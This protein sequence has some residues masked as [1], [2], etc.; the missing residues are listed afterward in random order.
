M[1]ILA[2][3]MSGV[4][5]SVRA[6]KVRRSKAGLES[7]RSCAASRL[8]SGS[9]TRLRSAAKRRNQPLKRQRRKTPD[10]LSNLTQDLTTIYSSAD[11]E[12]P[13]LL[14]SASCIRSGVA[15][16]EPCWSL[17]VALGWL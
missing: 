12:P 11:P 4:L 7:R 9:R 10:T 16:L 2:D 17:E 15:L 3:A 5:E 13:P 1:D 14:H 6:R 8:R